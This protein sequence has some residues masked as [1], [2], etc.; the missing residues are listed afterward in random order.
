[1]LLA[2]AAS[3]GLDVPLTA[4]F[5]SAAA[6]ATGALLL[7]AIAQRLGFTKPA[8][9]I[10]GGVALLLYPSFPLLVSTFGSE[11]ALYLML[12]LAV[13]ASYLQARY[14]AVGALLALA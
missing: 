3:V 13:L 11:S 8:G 1:M 2:G 12:C 5:I 7:C 14:T 10:A 4:N 9:L 6:L